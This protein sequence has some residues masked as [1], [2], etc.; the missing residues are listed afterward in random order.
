MIA[1]DALVYVD[2][3]GTTHLVG[4]LW[5]RAAR[6]KQSA[7][8]QYAAEWLA[9]P[10]RFALEPGLRIGSGAHHTAENRTLFGAI[11]DSAPDRW[12]RTL[13]N[14]AE[15]RNARDEERAPRTLREID[16]LLGVNDEARQGALRFATTPGGPFLSAGKTSQVPPLIALPRLLAA[17][18]HIEAENET[19]DDLH[20]LLA[21][22]SSLGGARPKASIRDRDGHLAMAKFPSKTD[23]YNVVCWE[24]VALSLAAKAGIT[25]SEWRI[26]KVA[27]RDTLITRRFDRD[28]ARRVPFLS[29]MSML[30]AGEHEPHSYLEIADAIRQ[31]GA[32]SSRDLAQLWRRIVF[33]VLISNTDDHLR[34]HGFIYVG[35]PGW[36]LSPAYDMNPVPLDVKPRFLATS[37]VFDDSTAA[38]E[39]AFEV[40][41]DFGLKPK[42]AEIITSEIARAVATWRG[43]AARRGLSGNDIERMAS[44]FEHEDLR[45]ALAL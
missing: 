38:L 33:S 12:G 39:L 10:S 27:G 32:A 15:R 24:G 8:F 30:A 37:I 20:L 34:N 40:A 4:H 17:S 9:N 29:A 16:Y 35:T 18:D 14:R 19:M 7:S 11:G 26:E 43:V 1:S 3:E 28:G 45:A 23:D 42:N 5:T 6:G 13:M 31:H 36:A 21:P 2:L 44:A 22:G 25:V 41:Q